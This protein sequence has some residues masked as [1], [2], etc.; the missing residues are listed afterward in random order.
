VHPHPTPKIVFFCIFP[1]SKDTVHYFF[2]E[3]RKTCRFPV[4]AVLLFMLLLRR[5]A[6]PAKR[7]L[8]AMALP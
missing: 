7:A 6:D 1:I 2:T 4:S 5:Q 3:V 8:G